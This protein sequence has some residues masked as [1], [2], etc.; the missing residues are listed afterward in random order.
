[1]K[2]IMYHYVRPFN[3]DLPNLKNLHIDDFKKQLDY[4]QAE[5]GFV[6]MEDF[7]NCFKTGKPVD[8][9]ILTFDDGL[10][11]HY[12]YVYKELK[13]RGLWGIFYI[14]T[15][16]YVEGKIL[17]VHR[18]HLLLGKFESREIFDF[19]DKQI[20]ESLF[21]HSKLKEFKEQTYKTQEN[22]QYTLLVK[23]ILNYYISYEYREQVMNYLMENFIPNEIDILKDFYLTEHQ[24]FEMHKNKMIIGSHTINHPVMSR[25]NF[26]DQSIQIIDSFNFLEKI[27]GKLY[28]KTFCYP[29]GGFHSFTDETEKILNQENC[30]YSFNVEHR[31]IEEKDLKFRPQALPRYDCNQFPFGQVRIGFNNV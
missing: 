3:P 21:D 8:G 11:C 17:D 25:L 15:Q 10:S 26:E 18:T 2:A 22:D 23:R 28:H 24:I 7:V 6:S 5:F 31:D 19:L 12:E 9:V 13:K 1:M 30:L 29:Y 20:N 14:P 4:F 16:P 27:V